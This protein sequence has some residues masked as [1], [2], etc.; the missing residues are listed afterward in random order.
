MLTASAAVLGQPPPDD[1]RALAARAA[2]RIRALQQ[3]AD[4]LAAQTRTLLNDLRK[5]DL[6]RAI[7]QQRVAEADA[8]LQSVTA[9]RDAAAARVE[10]LQAARIAGTPGVA[11][12]LMSIY[13]RGRGGYARLLLSSDDPRA[14]GRLTRG[15]AAIATLDKVRVDT[16]RRT[17]EAEREA[18]QT[19]EERHQQVAASQKAAAQAHDTSTR[20]RAF[21]SRW[22]EE[23]PG[24]SEACRKALPSLERSYGQLIV[25]LTDHLDP[26][27]GNGLD[28]EFALQEFLDRYGM[29]LA[30]LGTIL[31]LVGPLADAGL[32]GESS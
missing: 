13:K 12:R 31:N 11:E 4:Q 14:F 27:E 19:L 2:E 7:A 17:L 1:A 30:Q 24:L 5:L 16:H 22:K 9:E 25:E 10:R 15:V 18:L 6:D 20:W 21:L 8:A 3:E 26:E 23:F 29:R 32:G 28:N